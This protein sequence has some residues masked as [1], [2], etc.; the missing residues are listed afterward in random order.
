MAPILALQSVKIGFAIN[1]P[2]T[3]KRVYGELTQSPHNH[4]RQNSALPVQLMQPNDATCYK[5]ASGASSEPNDL[6]NQ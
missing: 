5:V 4:A 3:G 2:E 6:A 1:S